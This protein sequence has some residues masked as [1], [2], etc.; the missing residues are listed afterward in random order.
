MNRA[1][2]RAPKLGENVQPSTP[3]TN[4]TEATMMDGRRPQRS[5]IRP[6]TA[7]RLPPTTPWSNEPSFQRGLMNNSTPEITPRS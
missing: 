1:T 7:A 3:R 2:T 5:V 6:A 4:T